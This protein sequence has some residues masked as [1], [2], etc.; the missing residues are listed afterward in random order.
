MNKGNLAIKEELDNIAIE[1]T[2]IDITQSEQI[3]N[4]INE[5]KNIKKP[6]IIYTIIKKAVDV[7]SGIVGT[8]LLLPIILIVWIMRLVLKENDGPLF[9][10]QIRI[11]KNGKQFRMYKFR[12]MVMEADEKLFKY[13]EEN[14]EAKKEYK[15][16]KKLKN[17]PRITKLGKILRKTSLDEFPQFINVLKGEMSLVGPRPYLHREKE[18]LGGY[19]YDIIKNVKP[20]ITGYWQVN[21]RNDVDFEER[22]YMDTYYIEHRGIIMDLKIILK[23][24]LKI[25]RKEGAV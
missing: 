2:I 17:D 11:G 18:D 5:D 24:F 16:Y 9:F 20:G 1:D 22:A 10:E 25:F 4:I 21:G 19:Y 3:E 12:T 13:L 8:I 15:K 6:N 7:M 14:P 23:T